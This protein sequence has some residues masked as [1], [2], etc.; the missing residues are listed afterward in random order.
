MC[1]VTG[2]SHTTGLAGD[3]CCKQ[4]QGVFP[5]DKLHNLGIMKAQGFCPDSGKVAPGHEEHEEG[6]QSHGLAG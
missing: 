1:P 3:L 4:H 2:R 5:G 6:S